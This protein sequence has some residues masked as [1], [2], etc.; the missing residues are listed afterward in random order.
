[1][2]TPTTANKMEITMSNHPTEITQAQ[3]QNKTKPKNQL[4]HT[5]RHSKNQC[6]VTSKKTIKTH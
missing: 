1:M 5:A 4:H 3:S 2:K 6:K